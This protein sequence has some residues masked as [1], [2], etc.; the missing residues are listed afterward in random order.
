MIRASRFARVLPR[1]LVGRFTLLVAAV[2]VLSLALH[3]G[4]MAL[5]MQSLSGDMT[6]A[7]A[8]RVMLARQ[9]LEREPVA[10]RDA[11]A[12]ALVQPHFAL[13]RRTEPADE[14]RRHLPPPMQTTFD[15]L[16]ELVGPD[17]RVSL[18]AESISLGRPGEGGILRFD[19]LLSNG[20]PWRAATR[21]EPPVAALLGTGLGWLLLVALAVFAALALGARFIARPLAQL[22]AR[23]EAQGATLQALPP[24]RGG[25]S[26]LHTLTQSFNRLVAAVHRAEGDRQHLLAG[27][28][29]DLRTPLARLRLRIETQLDDSQHQPLSN[30]LL[31]DVDAIERIVAQFLAYVQ[32]ESGAAALGAPDVV[33]ELLRQAVGARVEQGFDVRVGEID[34]PVQACL[35][36]DLAVQR[37]L[38]NL[39]DNALAHGRAPVVVG[40][41]QQ[42]AATGL[43]GVLSVADTG[44]GM[45]ADEFERARL[46]FVR[47]A[48]EAAAHGHCGLGLA[49]VAQIARQLGGRLECRPPGGGT[50]PGFAIEF[51]WPLPGAGRPPAAADEE[52]R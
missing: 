21:L 52:R 19:F 37:V 18:P 14:G 22:A 10:G 39:I 13:Q 34:P 25:A 15:A 24:P 8:G 49:I 28:S 31:A 3:M 47:L 4:V 29:H 40:L 17:V 5:W 11:L 30:A 20:E 50:P 16:R 51:V 46:P 36:P 6:R 23:L 38:G 33:A 35:L 2:G 32:G 41:R 26:E 9:M 48:P 1:S 44:A 27:V 12:A 7:V 45:T 43:E 42:Q